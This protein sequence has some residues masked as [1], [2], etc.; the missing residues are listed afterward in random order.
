MSAKRKLSVI[1]KAFRSRSACMK[2]KGF[3]YQIP[4]DPAET[5][6]SGG[7][8]GNAE[9]S[10]ATA[11]VSCKQETNAVGIRYAVEKAYRLGSV[12]KSF[13]R[14]EMLRKSNETLLEAA[15]RV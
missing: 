12:N 7:P 13:E 8:A 14:L 4:M 9:K 1:S 5:F 2:K 15:S 11:D 6:P 3:D 10:T